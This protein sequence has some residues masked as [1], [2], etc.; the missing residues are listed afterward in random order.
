M[1]GPDSISFP[2]RR[3]GS[4]STATSPCTDWVT[5]RFLS[6]IDGPAD[7]VMLRPSYDCPAPGVNVSSYWRGLCAQ[8]RYLLACGHR[9]LSD[10]WNRKPSDLW[11]R[12]LLHL[13]HSSCQT[14]ICLIRGAETVR[15]VAQKSVRPVA[16]K[17]VRPVT[18]EAVRI[19]AQKAVKTCG[20]GPQGS[21]KHEARR[22]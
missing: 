17:A 10:L 13:R 5:R 19:V 7:S 18:H 15:P 1:T 2:F 20:I 11:H 4:S 9:K 6:A 22:F 16:Q 3:N 12:K 21:L 14:R 8:G